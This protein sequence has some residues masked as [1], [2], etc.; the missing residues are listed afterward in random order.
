M[1]E[2]PPSFEELIKTSELPVLVDFYADW[3]GPCKTLGPVISRL[4]REYKGRL[5]AVKIN[6][7][8]KPALSDLYSIQ[9]IPT[10]ML[11]HKEKQLM[12]LQGSYPYESLKAELEKGL[13]R[14]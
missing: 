9:S 11:F 2:L 1:K 10:I 3:C 6:T 14:V 13:A 7:E 12:R 8:K 5:I 4:A